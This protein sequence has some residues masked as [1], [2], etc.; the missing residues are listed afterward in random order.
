MSLI[1]G[2]DTSGERIYLW[3]NIKFLLI[4]LVVVGHFADRFTE[5]SNTFR[6]LFLF[7]YA[8]HMP[9]FMF[10]SGLFHTD[11]HILSK[12][13]YYTS[14][15]FVVKILI[16]LATRCSGGDLFF[17]LLSDDGIPW[18][19]FALAGYITVTYIL[20]NQ[21]K[22]YILLAFVVLALFVGYD[23]SVGDYLYL[24]RFIVFYPF[25]L[26]GNILKSPGIISFKNRYHFLWIPSAGII[27]AWVF[28]CLRHL[29]SFYIFRGLFT[30]RN[31]FYEGLPFEGAISR[32]ITYGI[33][34]ILCIAIVLLAPDREIFV[35]SEGGKNT[36]QVFVWHWPIFVLLN[37]YLH[38]SELFYVGTFG[39]IIFLLIGAL[40]AVLLATIPIFSFPMKQIKDAIFKPGK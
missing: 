24:S 29:D 16:A 2:G 19:M 11:R 20:R 1:G 9:L 36:L 15:G 18:F 35:V 25:Y 27:L 26:L 33:T 32:L 3:D 6:S 13:V 5:V 38:I 22:K 34:L 4:V 8:F 10:V 37:R 23:H 30:G 17:S 31:P 21:N 39:K 14:V 12:C 7:I 28:L 40:L